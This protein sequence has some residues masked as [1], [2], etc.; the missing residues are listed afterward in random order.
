MDK[1]DGF[2]PALH[3]QLVQKLLDHLE[4]DDAFRAR[5][6][7]SPESALRELGYVDPWSCMTLASGASLASKEQIKAQRVKLAASLTGVQQMECALSDQL[8]I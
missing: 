5:F 7:K 4:S 8:G 2:A 3:P 6:H 1:K